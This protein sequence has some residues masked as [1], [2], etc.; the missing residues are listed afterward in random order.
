MPKSPDL[1]ELAVSRDELKELRLAL[2]LRITQLQKVD[3][4]KMP[5]TQRAKVQTHIDL[6]NGLHEAVTKAL[7]K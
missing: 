2:A 3:I 7:A 1:S 4:H 5:P 6:C